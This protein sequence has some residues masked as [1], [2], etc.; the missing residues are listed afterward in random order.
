MGAFSLNS[1]AGFA[2][3]G[4]VVISILFA[5]WR[6]PGGIGGTGIDGGPGGIG[7]TGIYGRIDAFGSIWVNGV[8]IFY[9][10]DQNV[11]RQGRD[12]LPERLAIGQI[13][14][15]TIDEETGRA[16]AR[17]IEI[18][19]EVNGQIEQLAPDQFVVLGQTVLLTDET[20]IEGELQD[21]RQVAVNGLRST[22]GLVIASRIGAPLIEGE[23]ALRGTVER[24]E[25]GSFW[26]GDQEIF[27]GDK[28]VS[29]GYEV[30][31]R[32]RLDITRPDQ[33]VFVSEA[34]E[35]DLD[36]LF[37]DT[38]TR[39]HYQR[40]V[41]QNAAFDFGDYDIGQL[42]INDYNIATLD[43]EFQMENNDW[44]R[45]NEQVKD[46]KPL[47][48][49]Q[50]IA[51]RIAALR[52]D[53]KI[54]SEPQ[55]AANSDAVRDQNVPVVQEKLDRANEQGVSTPILEVEQRSDDQMP[56]AT[57]Q[58][59]DQDARS[60][61][62]I[63][64]Q[65]QRINSRRMQLQKRRLAAA[66]VRRLAAVEARRQAIE[67]ARAQTQN[68]TQSA[69]QGAFEPREL[70]D[71]L[72]EGNIDRETYEQIQRSIRDR[73]AREIRDGARYEARDEVRRRIREE[74]RRRIRR[75]LRTQ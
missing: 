13:V 30:D 18:V 51:A 2:F 3:I 28:Q 69:P 23:L 1:K 62:I 71:M 53:V 49:E 41:E 22:D 25:G 50:R 61:A 68:E 14:A 64:E 65:Q 52:V 70:E 43:V 72:R 39:R 32:G 5:L 56:L 9:D 46:F 54:I 37:D 34:F 45:L 6:M 19:E 26:V 57:P 33:P 20:I 17:T 60:R 27:L 67:Q 73:V 4:L 75:Q 55:Q 47:A 8:E 58:R 44:M 12:G 24:V 31:L 40:I 38:V 74:I 7:G 21:G 42:Q 48:R 10:E 66:N 35:A 11:V 36:T 63:A 15:V 59:I 29:V 16:I